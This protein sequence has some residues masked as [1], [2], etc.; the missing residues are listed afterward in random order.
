MLKRVCDV[1]Q[2]NSPT[3]K[4]KYKAKQLSRVDWTRATWEK[5]ELCEWC[6]INIINAKESEENEV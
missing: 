1:C 3:F 2:K 4:M 5:I 6:L